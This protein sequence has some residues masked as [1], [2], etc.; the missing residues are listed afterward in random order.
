MCV[1]RGCDLERATRS[2][3]PAHVR[4]VGSGRV[5]ER[6]RASGS[7]AGA[8][9]SPRRYATTSPRWR[10]GTGSIPA[11]ATSGADSAAQTTRVNPARRAPSA[12]ASA[13]ATG[14]HA[15]V[16]RELAD[17]RVLGEPLGRDLPCRREDGERDRQVEPRSLLAQRRGR[18]IDRDPAVERPLER[19]GDD[20]AADAVLRLLAGAVGEPDDRESRDAQ[21]EVR[22][23]LDLPRLEPDESVGDRACEH[24]ATVT[25][26]RHAMVTASVPER[27][28]YERYGVKQKTCTVKLLDSPRVVPAHGHEA[29]HLVLGVELRLE[30]LRHEL[31]VGSVV[32]P[33]RARRDR[34]LVALAPTLDAPGVE[35]AV[36]RAR[37]RR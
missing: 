2:F 13:P 9:I 8:S 27:S 7:K 33:G 36:D 26:R 16:E 22:L 29:V 20:A 25:R 18:E 4:E 32:T 12:T 21:L 14:P 24:R 6:I 10:T 34:A 5:L 19:G 11:S 15:S 37:R 35:D 30:L 23:D 3:L 1:A 31:E 17:R 28:S